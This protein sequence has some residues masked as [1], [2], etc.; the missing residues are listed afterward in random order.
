MNTMNRDSTLIDAELVS[1]LEEATG[2][3]GTAFTEA[4]GT[5]SGLNTTGDPPGTIG[6]II[7]GGAKLGAIDIEGMAETE[8]RG[9][10][11]VVEG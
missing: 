10:G 8:G 3:T 2:T 9:E 1:G 4:A 7:S 6:G 5:G 11:E